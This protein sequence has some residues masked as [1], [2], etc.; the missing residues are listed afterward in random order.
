[1]PTACCLMHVEYEGLGIYDYALQSLGY[2][3]QTHL[4]PKQGVPKELADFLLILGGPMSANDRHAWVADELAFV[5]KAVQAGQPVLGICLGAQLIAKAL[6]AAVYK[7]PQLEIGMTTIHLTPEGR[8]DP[9]FGKIQEPA[10]FFEWHGEG[11]QAPPGAVVMA[12]SRAY[13]V[14]AFRYGAKTVAILFH[15]EMDRT[16]IDRLCAHCPADIHAAGLTAS[17]ILQKAKLYLPVMH[18]WG[19]HL[20]ESLANA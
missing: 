9:I 8:A 18:R 5:R 19:Q 20:L 1:M 10:E 14:Q 7:G 3:V 4:T 2:E 13:P 6:G 17:S 12:S 16:D 11:M 15:P